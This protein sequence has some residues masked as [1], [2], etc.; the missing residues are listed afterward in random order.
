MHKKLNSYI[1]GIQIFLKMIFIGVEIG[2]VLFL[3]VK[4]IRI[5]QWIAQFLTGNDPPSLGG[6]QGMGRFFSSWEE[7]KN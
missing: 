6:D 5:A 3:V 1:T 7:K 2:V 4:A